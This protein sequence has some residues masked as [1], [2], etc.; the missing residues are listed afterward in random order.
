MT[1]SIRLLRES[2]NKMR[3]LLFSLGLVLLGA[4]AFSS[5]C[6]AV[7]ADTM[8]QHESN[9]ISLKKQLDQVQSSI[10]KKQDKLG[11]QMLDIQSSTDNLARLNKEK[12]KAHQ[13]FLRMSAMD[14]ELVDID[15]GDKVK[16]ARKQYEKIHFEFNAENAT[17]QKLKS[18]VDDIN[19][20]INKDQIQ[21]KSLQRQL[22]KAVNDLID[23]KL[24]AQVKKLETT[25][26]HQA[27]GE[28][29]CNETESLKNCR[30]RARHDA[31]RKIIEKGSIIDIKTVTEIKNFELTND[32][33]RNEVQANLSNIKVIDSGL[34]GENGFFYVISASVKPSIN[35]KLRG[36]LRKSI[37]NDLD[38][39]VKNIKSGTVSV[40]TPAASTFND[41]ELEAA[42]KRAL[43]AEQQQRELEAK[44]QAEK[45][46]QQL[47]DEKTQAAEQQALADQQEARRRQQEEAAR[48]A[49][50]EEEAKPKRKL[51]GGW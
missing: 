17:L 36:E 23:I 44:I 43:L 20:D 9:I 6:L 38:S 33:I 4:T 32:E 28:A 18:S 10:R 49:Q 12:D 25:Q 46:R 19:K 3:N 45:L 40:S 41:P 2:G 27:R 29:A 31:E 50:E 26:T 47:E 48:K 15:L 11:T 7:Q 5:S 16:E 24:N 14:I 21:N 35:S 1:Y 51:F 8:S 39:F 13:N 37:S 42:Q 34:H 30:G 22:D